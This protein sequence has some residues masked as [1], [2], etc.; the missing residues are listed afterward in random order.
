MGSILDHIDLRVRDRKAAAAFYDAFLGVLGAEKS[1]TEAFTTWRL[2][3]AGAESTDSF[4][5]AED[6]E[7]VAG[8]VRIAF[9]ARTREAVDAV[10]AILGRVGASN[11]EMDDGIYGDDVYAVFFEDPDGNRLE[12]T[13]NE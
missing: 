8:S 10:V 2:V 12:V 9:K 1:E 3:G 13:V 7:L 4:G 6:P 11:I 5:I